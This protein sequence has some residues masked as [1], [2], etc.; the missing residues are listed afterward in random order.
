[1]N[2]LTPQII[3]EKLKNIATNHPAEILDSDSDINPAMMFM[4]VYDQMYYTRAFPFRIKVKKFIKALEEKEGLTPS[5][6]ASMELFNMRKYEAGQPPRPS[7][8]IILLP[9]NILVM[10]HHKALTLYYGRQ[11]SKERI[12]ELADLAGQH[13]RK[14]KKHNKNHFFMVSKGDFMSGFELKSFE[15]QKTNINLEEHYNDDFLPVHQTIADFINKKNTNGLVLLHGK[16]GTGKTTYIRHLISESK[17]RIIYLPLHLMSFLSDPDFLP[18]ISDYKDSV[19][20]LEDC[21]DILKPRSYTEQTNHSLVNLLNLGDG[22]LSDALSIKVI[23]TF[24]AQ[25]KDIDQAILRKGR[26]VARYEFDTLS[27]HKTK[28]LLEKQGFEITQPQSLSLAEIYNYSSPDY[29]LS[30]SGRRLGFGH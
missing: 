23:C 1:M 14:D 22:L 3:E 17:R 20:V 28:S 10:I 30:Q 29:N 12:T 4:L 8:Y 13:R 18:F 6:Y 5:H 24:N 9:D 15:I 27:E 25:L 7:R 11:T 19:L 2:T 16:F 26:L 21:E